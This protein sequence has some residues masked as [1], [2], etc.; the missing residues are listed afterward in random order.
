VCPKSLLGN[1]QAEFERFAPE[2][3]VL[4]VQGSNR[5]KAL[6]QIAD[7]DVILTSYQLIIRDKQHYLNIKFGLILLDEASFIRN[8]DTDAAKTLR[9]PQSHRPN[10]PYR[11][12]VGKR[13]AGFVVHFPLRAAGLPREP[14]VFQGA[15]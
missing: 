11:N 15:V 6:T 14:E 7:H 5:E 13:R 3:K 4:Q 1:W 8:P 2:M 12:A 9:S 10:R